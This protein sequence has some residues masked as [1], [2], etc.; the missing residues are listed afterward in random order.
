MQLSDRTRGNRQKQKHKRFHLNI[1]KLFYSKG[2]GALE[3]VA[4]K[5]C[6]LFLGDIQSVTQKWPC[7]IGS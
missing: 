1:R 2:N 4:Q 3:Q 6:V 5:G 7:I